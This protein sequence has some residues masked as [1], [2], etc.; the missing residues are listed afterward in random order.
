MKTPEPTIATPVPLDRSP[1]VDASEEVAG[2][3]T[4][5]HHA[6]LANTLQK[7]KTMPHP[8]TKTVKALSLHQ[9]WASLIAAG[10]KTIETRSWPPP[11]SIVG[12]PLAIH[13]AKRVV[14]LPD[15]P[16]YDLFNAAVR[17]HLGS[18]WPKTVPTGAVVAVATLADAVTV[19]SA[20]DLPKGDELL[21]GDYELGRW[22][23]IL[24]DIQPLS[25]PI[26]A[27]GH[28]GIWNIELPASTPTAGGQSIHRI[29]HQPALSARSTHQD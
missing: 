22:L 26:A 23:W 21:F 25:S 14:Q 29:P 3:P 8:A 7:V 13:A 2:N 27:R 12:Q 24:T 1:A 28:Q 16:P 18:D 5:R 11:K 20:A 9:P 4:S 6:Q 19:R 10:A 17:R 15:Q